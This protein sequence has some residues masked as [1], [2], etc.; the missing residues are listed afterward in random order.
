MK[1]PWAKT[2]AL[3][4]YLDLY[5]DRIVPKAPD[6][7][8]Y[9][10]ESQYN[11]RPDLLAFDLYGSDRLWWVFIKR[12]MD[13]LND[14]VFDFRAGVSIYLPKKSQLLSALGN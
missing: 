8:L 12:N 7:Y 13:V 4:D 2:Q 5:V 10:I 9:T 3:S 11:F 6:D 14:P 1:S